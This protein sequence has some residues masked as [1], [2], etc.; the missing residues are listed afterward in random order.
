MS[1]TMRRSG[2]VL[3]AER[4]L[5]VG[6]SDSGASHRTERKVLRVRKSKAEQAE[7]GASAVRPPLR[8]MDTVSGNDHFCLETV[9]VRRYTICCGAFV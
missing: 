5:V 4:R 8:S 6:R 7:A 2:F 3:P 1:H 9:F